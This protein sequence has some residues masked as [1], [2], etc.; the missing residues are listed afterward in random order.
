M[1]RTMVPYGGPIEIRFM[2]QHYSTSA[3]II[4]DEPLLGAI[5][6]EDMN[7][8]IIPGHHAV[9]CEIGQSRNPFVACQI[10]GPLNR[11]PIRT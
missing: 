3:M 5:P 4:G 1:H 2:N 10:H 6:V 8:V 9:D 11:Q 7:P